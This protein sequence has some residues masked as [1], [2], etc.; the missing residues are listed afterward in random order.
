VESDHPT[1]AWYPFFA[2]RGSARSN[3]RLNRQT[4]AA[5]TT[6][7]DAVPLGFD[8]VPRFWAACE[9]AQASG[10]ER[11]AIFRAEYRAPG[12]DGLVLYD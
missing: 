12:S 11:A 8:D 3:R 10:Q 9:H 4:F 5:K 1:E 6:N 7:P 2:V